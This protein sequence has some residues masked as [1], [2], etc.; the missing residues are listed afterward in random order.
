MSAAD[1]NTLV[2]LQASFPHGFAMQDL[3]H[4]HQV[5][6]LIEQGKEIAEV[7]SKPVEEPPSVFQSVELWIAVVT[8]VV[9]PA[10]MVVVRRVCGSKGDAR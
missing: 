1:S 3:S 6:D 10:V 2:R 5:L 8:L 9:A 7:D 4:L